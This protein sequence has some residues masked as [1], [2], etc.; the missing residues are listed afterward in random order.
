LFGLF[1]TN[2][3]AL[4]LSPWPR[5]LRP[6]LPGV[7]D[8]AAAARPFPHNDKKTAERHALARRLSAPP[9][10]FLRSGPPRKVLQRRLMRS[11]DA[12]AASAAITRPKNQSGKRRIPMKY[13]ILKPFTPVIKTS[14]VVKRDTIAEHI[15]TNFYPTPPE[16]VRALLSVEKFYG[17]IHEP[18]CGKGHISRVLEAAGHRV[19]STD[20]NN[21]GYGLPGYDFL[22]QQEP[23]AD[24][25]IT[26]PPYG[27]G[28]ADAF[29]T[30]ALSLMKHT[31]GKVAMLLNLQSLVHPKRTEAWKA[32]PPARIYGIDSVLC[33]PDDERAP[34][35]HFRQHRYIWAVWHPYHSGPSRFWWLSSTNFR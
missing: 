12:P 8:R 34:P 17:S 18:A 35:E 21:W 10:I 6:K 3:F 26:N 27:S 30:K 7:P 4:W 22:R 9:A 25:I 16:A 2:P 31:R 13:D 15:Q 14:N 33:W 32:Q 24:H 5:D 20:L 23:M 28:L 29:V 1:S 11:G 19:I